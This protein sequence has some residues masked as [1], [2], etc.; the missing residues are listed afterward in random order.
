MLY[1]H[2]SIRMIAKYTKLSLDAI[3]ELAA[4]NNL[5]ITE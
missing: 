3:R 1:D 4:K 5:P 2:M